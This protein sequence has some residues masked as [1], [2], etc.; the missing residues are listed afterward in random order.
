MFLD[1]SLNCLI[2]GGFGISPQAIYEGTKAYR[3]ENGKLVL[4]R[5]DH[6]AIRMKVGAERMLMP[7]PSVDQFVDAVKQTAFANRRWVKTAIT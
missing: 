5:P 2:S 6:N 7:A 3:K 4:F 1:F